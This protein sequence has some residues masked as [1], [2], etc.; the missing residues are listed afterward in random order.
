M[1]SPQKEAELTKKIQEL[2]SS[3][4]EEDGS[5]SEERKK[6]LITII[7]QYK[8][9]FDEVDTIQTATIAYSMFNVI[10]RVGADKARQL[11]SILRKPHADFIL[12]SLKQQYTKND[13]I[14]IM[15]L[16]QDCSVLFAQPP[17]TSFL[18]GSIIEEEEEVE[19]AE[20]KKEKKKR[21]PTKRV[22]RATE[23]EF[24]EPEKVQKDDKTSELKHAAPKLFKRL[25]K[26]CEQTN[27]T[28]VDTIKF[29]TDTN[30][31]SKTVENFF[32]AAILVNNS[33][34]ALNVNDNNIPVLSTN[35][36]TMNDDETEVHR[37]IWT[38]NSKAYKNLLDIYGLDSELKPDWDK[39]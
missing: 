22:K 10:T 7:H 11:W 17:T 33:N 9:L 16:G 8:D 34:I 15:K 14:D 38:I 24:K 36:T 3:C 25:Q 2:L 35:Q 5:I 26:E 12:E 1:D 19:E 4:D 37:A 32:D 18:I 6:D 28:S 30:G 13:G 20:E 39:N 23:E 31:F 29:L 27:T 21:S